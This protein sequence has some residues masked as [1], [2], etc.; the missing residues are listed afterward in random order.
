MKSVPSKKSFFSV[1]FFSFF[2]CLFALPGVTKKIPDLSGQ[3]VY[4]EDKSF[5]RESYFGI[6]FYDE[7]TYGLR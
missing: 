7:G 3:F 6:I 1:L 2:S 5:E 4:Y